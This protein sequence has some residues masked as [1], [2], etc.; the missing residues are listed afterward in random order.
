MKKFISKII[1]IALITTLLMISSINIKAEEMENRAPQK[2]EDFTHS[3]VLELFVTTWCQYCPE[4]EREAVR[5]NYEYK[6]N[7]FFISMISDVN[8]KA[9]ERENDF[10]PPIESYPSAEFDGGYKD[11]RSGNADTFEGHIEDCGDRDDFDVDLEV[12]MEKADGNNINVGYRA[13]YNDLFPFYFD[14][15]LRIYIVEKVS[16]HNNNED[17]PIPYGFVDY[18]FDKDLQLISQTDQSEST[19][20]DA[21]DCDIDNLIVIGAIFD[22]TTG[23]EF[24]VQSASTEKYADFIISEVTQEPEQPTANDVVNVY[25]SING[26]PASVDLE[27]SYCTDEF[28]TTPEIVNMS[29]EGEKYIGNIGPFKNGVEVHY[30]I[31]AKDS[32]GNEMVSQLYNFTVGVGS[33]DNEDEEDNNKILAGTGVVFIAAVVGAV[34]SK[35]KRNI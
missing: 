27:Y 28:C 33:S 12:S 34:I 7:F 4:S 6:S 22:E 11:E 2:G 35:K 16:Q 9:E 3:V 32:E 1:A 23:T 30:Q 29:K 18:A 21:S 8:D 24:S 15:H 20:W 5:L 26:T 25:A 31:I 10:T 14:C 17:E 19:T 13:R